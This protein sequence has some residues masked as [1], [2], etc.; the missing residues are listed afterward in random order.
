MSVWPFLYVLWGPTRLIFNKA[1]FS[2]QIHPGVFTFARNC[3]VCLANLLGKVTYPPCK[4]ALKL[5][6]V[7]Y[8][9]LFC[10][11]VLGMDLLIGVPL[12][13]LHIRSSPFTELPR[14]CWL[15]ST[16]DSSLA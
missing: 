4:R 11:Y 7:Q 10:K 8:C 16:K 5:L 12:L 2:L 14:S 1:P 3:N 15:A 6:Y 13:L 9:I